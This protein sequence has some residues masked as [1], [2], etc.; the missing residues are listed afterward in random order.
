MDQM[1]EAEQIARIEQPPQ[2]YSSYG[3]YRF[4]TCYNGN[5]FKLCYNG[6]YSEYDYGDNIVSQNCGNT[7]AHWV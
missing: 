6:Y 7:W 3:G 2:Y 5:S 4:S 1:C